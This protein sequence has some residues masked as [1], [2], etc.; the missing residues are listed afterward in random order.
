MSFSQKDAAKNIISSIHQKLG[1]LGFE[2]RKAGILAL[3]IHTD[4]LCTVG[5]NIATGRAPG[6]LEIN[7][8]VGVRN[9][10]VERLVA[11]I[12][13]EIF[14]EVIP[15]TLA[16]NVGYMSPENRYLPCLFTADIKIEN[17]VRQVTEAITRHGL[18]FAKKAIDLNVLV[19]LMLTARFGIPFI[20]EYRIPVGFFLL[21]NSASAKD[22]LSNRVTEI[23]NRGD[24]A[25]IKYNNF[26]TRL[27]KRMD[28]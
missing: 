3:T 5:L 10:Q 14:D 17:L 21:G 8:V 23:G 27:L 9:Q 28:R 24:P 1:E 13:G 15:P 19:D 11:E 16:G 25:A 20:T 7:P 18:P 6:V 4:V 22:F 12:S 2:K 26:A